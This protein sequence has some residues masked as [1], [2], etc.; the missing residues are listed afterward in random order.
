[1]DLVIYSGME[2]Y[3]QKILMYV[4][5]IQSFI[6]SKA[7][8]II[9]HISSYESWF[10]LFAPFLFAHYLPTFKKGPTWNDA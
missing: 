6:L 1:M 5:Y 2:T 7:F 3:F 10:A 9:C 8:F 4:H